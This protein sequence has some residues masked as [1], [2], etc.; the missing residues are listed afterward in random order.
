[1]N[2]HHPTL[3]AGRWYTLTLC[4]QLGNVG[5]EVSRAARWQATHALR[6]EAAMDRAL[7]LLDLTI[8]GVGGCR[9]RELLRARECLVDAYFG[10]HEYGSTWTAMQKYFDA[11]ARAARERI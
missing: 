7:E 11:F 3:A 9:Q 5:S 10:G 2:A 4:E 8:A 6:A 1:M